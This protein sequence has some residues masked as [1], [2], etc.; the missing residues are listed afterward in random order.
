[1]LYRKSLKI[2][3]LQGLDR[4]QISFFYSKVAV[5]NELRFIDAFVDKLDLKRVEIKSRC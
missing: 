4:N 2:P 3:I 5:E 1:M